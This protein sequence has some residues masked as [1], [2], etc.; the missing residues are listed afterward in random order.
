[1]RLFESWE[2]ERLG[3][4]FVDREVGTIY[5][6]HTSAFDIYFRQPELICIGMADGEHRERKG[7]S[8]GG[9]KLTCNREVY[10]GKS[11][12]TGQL[13]ALKKILM[14]NEKEGVCPP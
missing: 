4:S 5:F 12:Q 8:G 11:K 7:L 6:V 2:K 13:V 10:K 3:M 14:N 9:Q 1:M